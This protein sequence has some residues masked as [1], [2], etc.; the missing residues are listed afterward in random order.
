MKDRADR[1]IIHKGEME[2]TSD[3]CAC[4]DCKF[5]IK[6]FADGYKRA[7]CDKYTHIKPMDILFNRAECKYY[8]SEF[9][10]ER[11]KDNNMLERIFGEI[12]KENGYSNVYDFLYDY[13]IITFPT[14]KVPKYKKLISLNYC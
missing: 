12:A 5:L 7:M 2:G 10:D 3:D 6:K 13:R 4:K 8:K 1:F 11:N 14:I 9:L